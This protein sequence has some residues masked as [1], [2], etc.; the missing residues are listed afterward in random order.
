MP[1]S[2]GICN[3]EEELRQHA[4]G[5]R[6]ADGKIAQKLHT[7]KSLLRASFMQT[8]APGVVH[9]GEE[10]CRNKRK[11]KKSSILEGNE[12]VILVLISN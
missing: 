3:R 2:R 11:L 10:K 12:T 5:R 6:G 9:C 4:D 1:I 7:L 8:T